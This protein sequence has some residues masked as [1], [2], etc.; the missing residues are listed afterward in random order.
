[1]GKLVSAG[2]K[3]DKHARKEKP[4]PVDA[5]LPQAVQTPMPTPPAAAPA[6]HGEYDV[7]LVPIPFPPAIIPKKP[8]S[9][10]TLL[11][12]DRRD[13]IMLGGG[14]IGTLL[15]ILAAAGLNKVANRKSPE[16]KSEG[17]K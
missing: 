3:T 2:G 12:L 9:Q 17:E 10:R 7:E 11:D 14:V 1:M 16:S 4:K 15:A 5:P 8:G 13:F 6:A